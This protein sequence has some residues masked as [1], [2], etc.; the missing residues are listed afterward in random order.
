MGVDRAALYRKI[1][2]LLGLQKSNDKFVK[3]YTEKSI[4]Y[5]SDIITFPTEEFI[6]KC[7]S[8]WRTRR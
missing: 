1:R 8:S 3:E 2:S 7:I 6:K 5:Y 4:E